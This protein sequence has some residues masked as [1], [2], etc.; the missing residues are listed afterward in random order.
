[1]PSSAGTG[2]GLPVFSMPEPMHYSLPELHTLPLGVN[3]IGKHGTI[4][5]GG[6]AGTVFHR[7]SAPDR[8]A[9]PSD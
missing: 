4:G 7:A 8:P 2:I 3:P 5:N 1:M 9:S 6:L